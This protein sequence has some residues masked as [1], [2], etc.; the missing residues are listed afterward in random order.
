MAAPPAVVPPFEA[1]VMP[2]VASPGA[3]RPARTA[4]LVALKAAAEAPGGLFF[5][6]EAECL[7]AGPF[8]AGVRALDLLPPRDGRGHACKD[9]EPQNIPDGR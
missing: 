8:V 4:A 1:Y 3:F 7:M 2:S 5:T 6:K 9:D